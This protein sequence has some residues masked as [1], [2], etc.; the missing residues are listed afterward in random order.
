ME[1]DEIINIAYIDFLSYSY[2]IARRKV[3]RVYELIM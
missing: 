2:I 1:T 3:N